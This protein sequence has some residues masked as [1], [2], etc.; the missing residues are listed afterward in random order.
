MSIDSRLALLVEELGAPEVYRRM[1][2]RN[3]LAAMGTMATPALLRALSEGGDRHRWEVCKTLV[4]IKDP[5][6]APAL[7]AVLADEVMAVRWV[8][9]EALIVLGSHA[10]PPLLRALEEHFNS[11]YLRESAHHVLWGLDR[12]GVL[13]PQGKDLLKLL[14]GTEPSIRIGVAAREA[15]AGRHA[16]VH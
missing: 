3:E 11:V 16:Q 10:V 15:L 9:A 14:G 5:Q 1:H 6:A 2:A 12:M 13:G 7:V 8:A 4:A